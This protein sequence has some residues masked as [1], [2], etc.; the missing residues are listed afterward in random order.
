MG[1]LFERPPARADL[2]EVGGTKLALD[3]DAGVSIADLD[4][5]PPVVICVG[6]ERAGLR[7]DVRALADR[8]ARIPM[9]PEGPDSLNAAVAAAVAMHELANRMAGNA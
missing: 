8:T 7:E 6:A 1:S 5:E 2:G 4:L 9:R 3:P